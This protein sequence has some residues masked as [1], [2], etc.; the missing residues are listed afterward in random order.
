MID[1]S[2]EQMLR[3][4]QSLAQGVLI[5]WLLTAH[6]SRSPDPAQAANDMLVLAESLSDQMTFPN[7][8]PE[9]SDLAAQE[10]RDS[11]VCHIHRAKALA[12]NEPFDSTAFQRRAPD[13]D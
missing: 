12:T 5:E 11:L 10:F 8:G 6:F 1:D 4:I 3:H 7:V 9:Q 2:K 13:K